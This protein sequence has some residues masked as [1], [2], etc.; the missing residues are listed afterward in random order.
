MKKRVFTFLLCLALLLSVIGLSACDK[1][2]GNT[3]ETTSATSE[4]QP[5]G[6]SVVIIDNGAA[7][8]WS[9][10]IP[11]G[12]SDAVNTAAIELRDAIL[13]AT[14]VR[15]SWRDD[16]VARG[17]SIP[18][19]GKEI[20]LGVTNRELS[21][22]AAKNPEKVK[23][24]SIVAGTEQIAIVAGREDALSDAVSG[25]I[26][27]YI[28]GKSLKVPQNEV[29]TH[30]AE[31]TVDSLTLY[32][33]EIKDFSIL[34]DSNVAEADVLALQTLLENTVGYRLQITDQAE[35]ES[36]LIR[37]C[38]GNSA[39]AESFQADI[40]HF[41][42]GWTCTDN[43]FLFGT[44]AI[45]PARQAIALFGVTYL[46]GESKTVSIVSGTEHL[47]SMQTD[48]LLEATV[49]Y[50]EALQTKADAMKTQVLSARPNLD[51]FNGTKYY[52]SNNG[53]DA[54]DG[55][56]E[57]APWK[58]LDKIMSANLK[59]GDVILFERG[60]EW[61]GY[62]SRTFA[63]VLFTNYGDLEKPLP[64]L[65]GSLQNYADESLWVEVSENVWQCTVPLH[66]VGVIVFDH[67]GELGDYDA[68]FGNILFHR[69]SDS[70]FYDKRDG[71]PLGYEDLSDD[72]QFYSDLATNTLYLYSEEGNP[73]TRFSSIEIGV[74]GSLINI[75]GQGGNSVDGLHFRFS[76]G[77]AVSGGISTGV[78]IRNCVMEWIGGSV[79][80]ED[81]LYGNAI[82]IYGQARNFTVENNWI[83]QIYDTGITFQ[84][85]SNDT[86]SC[87]YDNIK[88]Q[89][90]L[91][92][93]C[94]W[95]I[96]FYNQPRTGTNRETKN[97]LIENNF[98]RFGGMGWGSAYRSD[99][100]PAN[101]VRDASA[102]LLCSWGLTDTTENFV[103]RNNVFEVCSG[104]L[105]LVTMPKNE[106]DKKI[107]WQGN[108]YVQTVEASF[109]KIA[110]SFYEMDISTDDVIN[111]IL[112]D[113]TGVL[114][115]I[116]QNGND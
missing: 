1:G 32:G 92:E 22:A 19:A 68:K 48:R 90:N 95:G 80:D 115:F 116:V 67:S 44:G 103:I 57:A 63:G 89:N 87:I 26:A 29:Y 6:E 21:Q 56:S 15:L 79:L 76:G 112:S 83:Y 65:N 96:E 3:D 64:I 55:K 98:C 34:A 106:G 8:D 94:H 93:Y 86:H 38:K 78:S 2:Q 30:R 49:P 77:F 100:Q 28:S 91:V 114:A 12:A 46:S 17:E 74:D 13:A 75:G 82:Q 10:V 20:L 97:V 23:D 52:I 73:G 70:A 43:A 35:G 102:A 61:R 113:E 110:G 88:F 33:K 58:T 39:T 107:I 109:G 105:G 111:N 16:F 69:A 66:D 27:K 99:R 62:L 72:L 4:E 41:D 54:N 59:K 81:M 104:A 37:F 14:G 51:G 5:I 9:I 50:L 7:S 24:Y 40:G 42:A 84:I 60:G 85:S 108:T 36:P 25:F 71:K 45:V 101:I 11:E 18:T 31:Y 47:Q 53:D